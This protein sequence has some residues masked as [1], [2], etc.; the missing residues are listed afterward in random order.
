M[1][2]AGHNRATAKHVADRIAAL[3]GGEI[4][5]PAKL[6]TALFQSLVE[7]RLF[8]AMKL[9]TPDVIAAAGPRDLTQMIS[10]LVEKRNL[11]RGEPTAIV[12]NENRGSLEQVGQLLVQEMRRRGLSIEGLQALDTMATQRR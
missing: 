1:K 9:L 3:A 11:L 4:D 7:E 6:D 5:T 2:A 12:R 10:A 8:W